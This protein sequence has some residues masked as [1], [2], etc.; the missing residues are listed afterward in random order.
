MTVELVSVGV[1]TEA[2]VVVGVTIVELV[3]VG[4]T[5]VVPVA[6]IGAVAE[7]PVMVAVVS[8]DAGATVSVLV[9]PVSVF[10]ARSR[11]HAATRITQRKTRISL[12]MEQLSFADRLRQKMR[13]A[14]PWLAVH[15]D[16]VCLLLI[17][18]AVLRIVSTLT[19]FSVTSDEPLHVTA[20][21]Q[22]VQTGEY[23]WQLENPPVPRLL[24]GWLAHSS[25]A[26]FDPSR[27]W[28]ETMRWLFH[29]S[30]HYKTTLFFARVGN[31]AFFLI[32]ALATWRLARRELGP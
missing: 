30:G 17:A 23:A 2:V 32:A 7:V 20:G 14:G 15:A 1:V 8:F 5:S 16:L 4:V 25:G 12:R 10:S 18:L 29:S 11:L 3:S 9:A 6:T 26:K 13:P 27:E 22:L 21:L 31:V 28:I 24:F 19:V